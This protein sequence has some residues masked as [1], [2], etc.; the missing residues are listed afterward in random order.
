[1]RQETATSLRR[2]RR[3]AGLHRQSVAEQPDAATPNEGDAI[4]GT[5]EGCC[6]YELSARRTV[7][8][9]KGDLSTTSA[10]GGR[11]AEPR[12][13]GRENGCAAAVWPAD[14]YE[15]QNMVCFETKIV[16]MYI[17]P[18]DLLEHV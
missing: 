5:G 16:V 13:R 7:S 6:G 10:G 2:S 1:M 17:H 3:H 11:R 9:D 12:A 18:T 15:S 14:S 8:T 4:D